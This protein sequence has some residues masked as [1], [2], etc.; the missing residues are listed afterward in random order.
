MI[1]EKSMLRCFAMV[2]FLGFSLS[3]SN[4]G[5]CLLCVEPP[6][7]AAPYCETGFDFGYHACA[8]DLSGC[9]VSD[10]C[11]NDPP[12]PPNGG[13]GG[14]EPPEPPDPCCPCPGTS[15]CHEA[16][17]KAYLASKRLIFEIEG[18]WSPAPFP[19][20]TSAAEPAAIRQEIAEIL[21]VPTVSV[22]LKRYMF[23]TRRTGSSGFST[24]G[25]V[26]NGTGIIARVEQ[27]V[28]GQFSLQ[29]CTFVPGGAVTELVD[30][31]GIDDDRSVLVAT[32]LGGA[33]VVM[34][35]HQR[36]TDAG[37]LVPVQTEFADQAK[38]ILT[39]SGQYSAYGAEAPG[40][41]PPEG[42]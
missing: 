16:C 13:G 22:K 38:A 3:T 37:D 4:A 33:P 5:L 14:G 6:P 27:P 42:P 23:Y 28:S 29:V 35:F 30:L 19:V 10:A 31:Q 20:V 7:P 34:A 32:T 1:A 40:G 41:C 17:C 12:V 26:V 18:G 8:W 15:T 24:Q 39:P 9:W 25:R 36:L 11:D 2:V 21:D